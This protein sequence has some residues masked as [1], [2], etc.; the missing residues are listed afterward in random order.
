LPEI[1]KDRPEFAQIH[2]QV[3][4]DALKQKGRAVP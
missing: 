4:Q 1:K 2:S 3:I